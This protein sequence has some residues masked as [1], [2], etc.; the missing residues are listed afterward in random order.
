MEAVPLTTIRRWYDRCA[1]DIEDGNEIEEKWRAADDR[2][3]M[4][5]PKNLP[6][7]IE[8]VRNNTPKTEET[9]TAKPPEAGNAGKADEAQ[10]E[11]P[12]PDPPHS[13][14][15]GVGS[16]SSNSAPGTG[17]KT[18]ERK[19]PAAN[20]KSGEPKWKTVS[21]PK[22]RRTTSAGPTLSRKDEDLVAPTAL[23]ITQG[24]TVQN[25]GLFEEWGQFYLKLVHKSDTLTEED[26]AALREI[27]SRQID[28][29]QASLDKQKQQQLEQQRQQQVLVQQLQ[30]NPMPRP[31]GPPKDKD[32]HRHNPMPD[33][34]A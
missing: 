13:P 11:E 20:G 18:E 17:T 10:E 29:R 34:K 32:G 14:N 7:R 15:E 1:K 16:A 12:R 28:E 3:E 9:G 21:A 4:L 33:K 8:Q 26:V 27:E 30:N 24:W 2:R 22:K 19:V 6:S 23:N 31:E 25:K 5:D